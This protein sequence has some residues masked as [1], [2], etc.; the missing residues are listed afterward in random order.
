MNVATRSNG[1]SLSTAE[2]VVFKFHDLEI[3]RNTLVMHFFDEETVIP[4]E[5]IKSY[6]LTWY[7]HDPTFAKKYWFLVLTVDL[8]NGRE[9][10]GPIAVAKFNYIDDERKLRRHIESKIADAIDL[11]L[12]WGRYS[13]KMSRLRQKGA[14][15]IP[16]ASAK[17]S[18]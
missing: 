9:E 17:L 13:A 18:S 11:A 4:L 7:L 3:T 5:D 1:D 15:P 8:R 6:S 2:E 12:S 16:L 10:S 14:N